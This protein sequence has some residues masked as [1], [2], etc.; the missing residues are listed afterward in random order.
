MQQKERRA[1][2]KCFDELLRDLDPSTSFLH[3]L[4]AENV[5]TE[6]Q[7][8]RISKNTSRE[9]QVA[10]LLRY[11]PSRGPMA[12]TVFKEKL[13]KDY[14]WLSE[15]LTE[16][17]RKLQS[18]QV[19]INKKLLTVIATKLVPLVYTDLSFADL[20]DENAH[21]AIIIQKLSDLVNNLEL[22]C[23]KALDMK[24]EMKFPLHKLIEDRLRLEKSSNME[25]NL[26]DLSREVKD[27]KKQLKEAVKLKGDN[28]KLK[29]IVNRQKEKLKDQTK[30][31]QELKKK[32]QE[33]EKLRKETETLRYEVETLREQLRSNICN[34]YA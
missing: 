26:N 8:D 11:L 4:Y 10:M 30:V 17:L 29:Q 12:F 34:I 16:E 22:K 5:L 24:T 25:G 28:E 7:I 27:L 32:K 3:S 21:P 33:L 31:I 14:P 20:C 2:D 18:G 15:K 1:L 6:E 23:H 13:S 19:N 9:T